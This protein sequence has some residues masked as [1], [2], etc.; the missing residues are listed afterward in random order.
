MNDGE[1]SRNPSPAIG[2]GSIEFFASKT[3]LSTNF[4]VIKYY[5]Q[6]FNLNILFDWRQT[7]VQAATEYFN[8]Y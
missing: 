7:N 3:L 4:N 2:Q 8:I 6:V 1:C 5:L